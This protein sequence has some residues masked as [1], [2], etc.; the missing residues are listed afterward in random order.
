[1]VSWEAKLA[2]IKITNVK[3]NFRLVKYDSFTSSS[4]L[5]MITSPVRL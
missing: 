3:V 4:G 2:N 1:M 5:S